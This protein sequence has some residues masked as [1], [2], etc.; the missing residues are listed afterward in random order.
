MLEELRARVAMEAEASDTV[1]PIPPVVREVV[2][3]RCLGGAPANLRTRVAGLGFAL[4]EYDLHP[5]ASE[6]RV[7]AAIARL[8]SENGV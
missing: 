2:G 4:L 7:A 1:M 3:R 6:G 5:D 8:T